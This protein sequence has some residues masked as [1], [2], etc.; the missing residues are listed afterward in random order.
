MSNQEGPKLGKIFIYPIKS[1]A[2]IELDQA[3]ISSDG[4]MHPD[5]HGVIDRL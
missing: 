4:I 5:N 1:L 3:L 2:G